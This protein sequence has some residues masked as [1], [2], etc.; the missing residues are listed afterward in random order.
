MGEPGARAAAPGARA[1][2]P[3]A[4]RKAAFTLQ[5][6]KIFSRVLCGIVFVSL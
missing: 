6:L 3:G 5:S 2:A 1:A 4:V